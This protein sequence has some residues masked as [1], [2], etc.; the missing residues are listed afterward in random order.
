MPKGGGGTTI[1]FKDVLI[2]NFQAAGD[3]DTFTANF[4][5]YEM[6]TSPP[7]S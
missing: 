6:G 2:S 4:A 7:P 3:V 5:T 1:T